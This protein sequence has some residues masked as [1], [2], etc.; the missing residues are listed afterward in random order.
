MDNSIVRLT[1]IKLKNF[2]NVKYGELDFRNHRKEYNASILGLYGQNGSGKTALIE[3][4]QILKYLLCGKEIPE[5]FWDCINVE[6]D[7]VEL[8][9]IF[10]VFISEFSGKYE[11]YYEFKMKKEVTEY[12]NNWNEKKNDEQ[13]ARLVIY[14]EI[15]S[16]SYENKFDKIRKGPLI[17]TRTESVFAPV[18]KYECLIGKDKEVMTDLLVAKRMAYKTSR[19][20]IFSSEFINQCRKR[21]FEIKEK[22]NELSCEFYRHERLLLRLAIFGGCELFVINTSNTGLISMNRLPLD[23]KYKENGYEKSGHLMLY[24]D[25]PTVIFS[26]YMEV[27]HKVITDMN[28]VLQQ[29]VPGLTISLK[30][31]GTQVMDDGRIGNRVQLMSHK[32]SKEI[33]LKNE[34]DGI[35]KII[36]ILQLLI[37]VYNNPSITVAIDE[38]DSGIF[39]YLLGEILRIISEKGK[40]QL[41]FTSHN[42]RP[43][44]TIDRGFIA[45]TTTN[46]EKRYTRMTKVKD[47]NNLRDFYFRDIVL[48]EQNEELYEPT[49]NAEIAFAFREAGEVS[50][51]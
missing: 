17:D 47:N 43:L 4:L 5:D 3:A 18:S 50:G 37:V 29:I 44:E 41:I 25:K 28:I 10:D 20:F 33:P 7:H 27:V 31:L 11:A 30:D 21:Q 32:N 22:N 45:F 42:L 8:Q 24:L 16:Y 48:G 51:T 26:K 14:D 38:L 1:G 19:S 36:S 13:K 15:L 49:N 39:E 2:K 6:A 46:P 9:F 34:S 23:F 40:G 35:K 12:A